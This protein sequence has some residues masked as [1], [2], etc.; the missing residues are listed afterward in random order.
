MRTVIT[1]H[2]AAAVF[3]DR[4]VFHGGGTGGNICPGSI[5]ATTVAVHGTVATLTSTPA[6]LPNDVGELRDDVFDLTPTGISQLA[7]HQIIVG[8]LRS[9][10]FGFPLGETA[11]V[12]ICRRAAPVRAG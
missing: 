4:I 7:A 12:E 11:I 6:G 10:F 1:L 2:F 8:D 9:E 3:I 5:V